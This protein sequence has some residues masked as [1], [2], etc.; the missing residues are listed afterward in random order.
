MDKYGFK[1]LMIAITSIEVI[2]SALLYFLTFSSFIYS[3]CVLLIA[4]CIGGNFTIIS[5]CFNKIFGIELGPKV[6]GISGNFIGISSICG[7]LMTK[8]IIKEV[9]DYLIVF[10]ISCFIAAV[11]LGVLYKFDENDKFQIISV[12]NIENYNNDEIAT[13]L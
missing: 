3:L 10:W 12:E 4:L 7:P 1:P 9:N 5:P 11:K 13:E 8:F 6:Y 2:I